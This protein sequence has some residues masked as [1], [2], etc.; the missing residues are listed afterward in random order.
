M[1]SWKVLFK[2]ES[3]I[4]AVEL[5]G[6]KPT[7][8]ID[9]IQ[10]V[11]LEQEDGRLK[12][13]PVIFF[14]EI[15]R[16]WVICKTTAFCL[17]AMFGE[18]TDGWIGKRVTLHSELVQVGAEKQPG[19]RVTGSP[20]LEQATMMVKIKLPKKKAFT[21]KLVKTTAKGGGELKDNPPPEAPA[22]AQQEGSVIHE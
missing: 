4:A 11:K 18:N 3:F 1:P 20:D 12:D 7:L 22:P 15:K 14:K 17:G 9:R 19:I 8:T 21:T 2:S 16:G 13:K 5:E 6:K 10:S